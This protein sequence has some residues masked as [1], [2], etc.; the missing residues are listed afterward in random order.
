MYQHR[1]SMQC[2]HQFSVIY[3]LNSL[4]YTADSCGSDLELSTYLFLDIYDVLQIMDHVKLGIQYAF[5]TNNRLTFVVSGT[6]ELMS[7]VIV[8]T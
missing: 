6:G 5:Q 8:L 1:L 7:V 4:R 3:I 2:L